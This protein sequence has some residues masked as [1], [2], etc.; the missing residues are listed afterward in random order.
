MVVASGGNRGGASTLDGDAVWAFALNGNIDEVPAP[1]PPVKKVEVTGRIVKQGDTW[2]APGNLFDDVVFDGSLNMEDYRFF[3]NRVQ[4]TPG[5][6]VTWDN[7]GAVI[8][9]A[10]DSTGAFDTGDVHAGQAAPGDVPVRW[11]VHVQL[12]AAPVDDRAGHRSV[13]SRLHV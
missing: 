13:A 11:D 5:S 4:V 6:T 12:H 10:T 9:T 3:P 7:K 2:A 8:H 1:P